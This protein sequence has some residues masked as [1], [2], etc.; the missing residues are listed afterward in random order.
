MIAES[1]LQIALSRATAQFAPAALAE[2]LALGALGGL[3]AFE[4]WVLWLWLHIDTRPPGW[5]ESL[6]LQ[7]T[8]AWRR[9]FLHPSEEALLAA[10]SLGAWKTPPFW[11]ALMGLLQTA[12]GTDVKLATWLCNTLALGLLLLATY[13]LGRLFVSRLAGGCAAALA[14]VSSGI[15][16]QEHWYLLDVP[17]A[18]MVAVALYG[19]ARLPRAGVQRRDVA[20]AALLLG[21]ACLTKYQ[22]AVFL[23][24]PALVVVGW[25]WRAERAGGASPGAAAG[26]ALRLAAGLGGGAALLVG[27][28]VAAQAGN[29]HTFIQDT[30]RGLL[31]PHQQPYVGAGPYDGPALTWYSIGWYVRSWPEFELLDQWPLLAL[32]ALG[33][34]VLFAQRQ[35]TAMGLLLAWIAGAYL[36]L[37]FVVNKEGRF[38]LALLPAIALLTCAPLGWLERAPWPRA[39][40]RA[41]QAALVLG[42]GLYAVFSLGWHALGARTPFELATLAETPGV[43]SAAWRD[44]RGTS[45]AYQRDAW[46]AAEDWQDERILALLSQARASLGLDHATVAFIPS[47]AG[48]QVGWYRYRVEVAGEPLTFV[49]GGWDPQRAAS[50]QR[51]LSAEFVLAKTG[52]ADVSWG[53]TPDELA[54][55]EAFSAALQDP[56]TDLGRQV[57]RTLYPFARLPLPDGSE[58]VLYVRRKLLATVDLLALLDSAQ[59]SAVDPAFVA[60]LTVNVGGDRRRAL[61]EHPPAGNGATTVSYRLDVVPEGAVLDCGIA[62]QSEA[63]REAGDGVEFRIDVLDAGQTTTLFQQYLDPK[64]QRTDRRWVD[65]QLDLSRYAGR[66]VELRLETRSGPAGDNRADWAV[67]S[68]PMILSSAAVSPTRLGGE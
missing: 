5:D 37:W 63:W 53:T 46:P 59:I 51:L 35:R 64:H 8:E 43:G 19:L 15:V 11:L 10:V 4:G 54:G 24:L 57:Q 49:S 1:K 62:L 38:D 22:A 7:M 48:L 33:A 40:A 3:L 2:A 67:W 50:R 6:Y 25:R 28:F 55:V 66:A 61:L 65:L 39:R 32:A 31:T 60:P 44:S 13:G 52:Q 30:V 27:L 23:W 16:F 21:L 12:L 68:E 41:L 20:L 29:W 56:A 58:A 45:S 47:V 9:F 18:A 42:V 14:S 36:G 26:A 34:G 17:L